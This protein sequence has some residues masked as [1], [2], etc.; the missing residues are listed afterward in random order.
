MEPQ[1]QIRRLRFESKRRNNKGGAVT[2][3]GKRNRRRTEDIEGQ[4]EEGGEGRRGRENQN[5]LVRMRGTNC[6]KGNKGGER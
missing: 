3:S 5:E 6:R 4:I 1:G 2:E